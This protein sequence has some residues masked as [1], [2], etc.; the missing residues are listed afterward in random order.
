MSIM[1]LLNNI[2]SDNTSWWWS[3]VEV[4]SWRRIQ[5]NIQYATWFV[6]PVIEPEEPGP[7][8][9]VVSSVPSEQT[10]GEGT[11]SGPQEDRDMH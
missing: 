4:I 5:Q 2:T 9:P 7:A 1:D 3:P 11:T 10:S 8:D 6:T